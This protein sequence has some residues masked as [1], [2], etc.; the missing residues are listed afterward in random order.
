M[1][2]HLH[3]QEEK[4]IKKNK[5]RYCKCPRCNDY[6]RFPVESINIA[7]LFLLG[8]LWYFYKWL[9]YKKPPCTHCGYKGNG[10]KSIYLETEID[11]DNNE[12]AYY[13]Q[14]RE[15]KKVEG[16]MVT[17]K[18]QRKKDNKIIIKYFFMA[19]LLGIIIYLY[20]IIRN[21]IN[22]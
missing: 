14:S 17:N 15:R 8:P 16:I 21:I 7:W 12:I 9:I 19:S 1:S 3:T 10:L 6:T 20:Y 5:K 4:S 11:S 2:I 13:S 22:Y 18:T